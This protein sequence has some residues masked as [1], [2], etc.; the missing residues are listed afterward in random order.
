ML[1]YHR[2]NSAWFA[3][4]LPSYGTWKALSQRPVSEPEL[5]RWAMYWT[6]LGAF[7]AVEYVAEWFISL[8]VQTI[9]FSF[10]T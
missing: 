4:F 7:V 6:V 5:E 8:S 3:F 10:L 2:F 9:F 1:K